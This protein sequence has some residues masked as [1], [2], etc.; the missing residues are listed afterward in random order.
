MPTPVYEDGTPIPD[1]Q[2]DQAVADQSVR[3]PVGTTHARV[4]RDGSSYDVPLERLPFALQSGG[5]LQTTA[6]A[7]QEATLAAEQAKYGT[8]EEMAKTFGEGVVR[9]VPLVGGGLYAAGIGSGLIDR[10]AS[11]ARQRTN[12][13]TELAGEILSPLP[14]ELGA[15]G[16]EIAGKAVGLGEEAAKIG[17]VLTAPTRLAGAK[18]VEGGVEHAVERVGLSA[19]TGKLAGFAGAG[20]VEGAS[21]AANQEIAQRAQEGTLNEMDGSDLWA[22]LGHGAVVGGLVGGGIG[23]TTELSAMAAA[24]LQVKAE[25]VADD[26]AGRALG[27]TGADFKKMAA[28]KPEGVVQR[29]KARLQ[30]ENL[31]SPHGS[32]VE[33]YAKVAEAKAEAG[34]ALNAFRK[35]VD[36]EFS[37]TAEIGAKNY[38]DVRG[39]EGAL[40]PIPDVQ[41]GVSRTI[42]VDAGK[43]AADIRS[44]LA[45]QGEGV[46]GEVRAALTKNERAHIENDI[47]PF[48][49]KKAA[50]GSQLSYQDITELRGAVS[51]K[52]AS[53][54]FVEKKADALEKVGRIIKD[55]TIESMRSAETAGLLPAGQTD[56]YIELNHR[57][58]DLALIAKMAKPRAAAM[59]GRSPIGAMDKVLGL[60]G[61]IAA[62][63]MGHPGALAALATG[64]ATAAAGRAI[65]RYANP[66]LAFT[67]KRLEDF[68]KRKNEAIEAIATYS[69]HS[70]V[71]IAT[72]SDVRRGAIIAAERLSANPA[73]HYDRAVSSVLANSDP[74][75]QTRQLTARVGGLA[76]SAPMAFSGVVKSATQANDYLRSQ[77]PTPNIR[78]ANS[79]TPNAEKPRV[80]SVEQRRFLNKYEAVQDP[81]AA[82]RQLS[83]G[84]LDLDQIDAV[85][86]TAPEL[87]DQIRSGVALKLAASGQEMPFKRRIQLGLAFEL[88][89]DKSLTHVG[90]I[91]ATIPPSAS[92][93]QAAPKPSST[94]GKSN[95]TAM[96]LPSQRAAGGY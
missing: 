17:Q 24:K 46:A 90:E 40:A 7:A 47:L 6:E 67:A 74:T 1:E 35:Q 2:L 20:A 23:A 52:S 56:K 64:A 65:S 82:L 3:F 51:D 38:H 10:E 96:S 14:G 71:K 29:A 78:T 13:G 19:I 36:D 68:A 53:V 85:K 84:K 5:R 18:A 73:K 4:V 22:A 48:I 16:L 12:P 45:P 76:H 87:Y 81:L 94:I 70:A 88:P 42:G 59:A 25:Q 72:A 41:R 61:A 63:S 15:K 77:L 27:L 31:V 37:A 55:N 49:D 28:E 83:V 58:E 69:L 93:T 34:Q 26:A 80:S 43:L 21:Y 32:V 79:L 8:P 66:I 54:R 89:A 30:D 9:G 86:A 50:S 92:G 95:Q 75:E 11:A 39:P 44:S 91:Q 62:G 60:G 33:N 57:Y